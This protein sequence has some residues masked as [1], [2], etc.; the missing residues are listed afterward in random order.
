MYNRGTEAA[1]PL[2]A[3]VMN[4]IDLVIQKVQSLPE[5]EQREVLAFI[6]R[7]A[8]SNKKQPLLDPYGM[9]KDKP[10][11]LSLDD[12]QQARK[13][14]WANFPRAWPMEKP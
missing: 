11:D 14:A 8:L 5:V 1:Y 10:T 9:C 2:E 12:F 3:A 6:E 7:L 4:V 13:E